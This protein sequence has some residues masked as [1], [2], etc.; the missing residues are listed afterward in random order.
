[1]LFGVPKCL[2]YLSLWR[3]NRR[4]YNAVK[5]MEGLRRALKAPTYAVDWIFFRKDSVR[6][7][8]ADVNYRWTAELSGASSAPLS[9]CMSDF[10]I[11]CIEQSRHRFVC[12]RCAESFSAVCQARRNGDS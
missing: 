10:R 1:M 3:E 5:L 9:D 8:W 2:R 4:A 6:W 7:D 12:V 11:S